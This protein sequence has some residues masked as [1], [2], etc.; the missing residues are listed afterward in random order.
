M[1]NTIYLPIEVSMPS[2]GTYIIAFRD[3]NDE[4]GKKYFM[5]G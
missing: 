1:P 3:S 4:K 5:M 2:K